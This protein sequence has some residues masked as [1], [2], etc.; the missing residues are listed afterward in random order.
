MIVTD[1]GL[2]NK[3]KCIKP[4]EGALNN[5]VCGGLVVINRYC[6]R[7]EWSHV[8]FSFSLCHCKHFR[9]FLLFTQLESNSELYW[10][11]VGVAVGLRYVEC[12]WFLAFCTSVFFCVLVISDYIT[13]NP[14]V[15]LWTTHLDLWTTFPSTPINSGPCSHESHLFE[16]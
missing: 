10:S 16:L 6:S 5:M 12:L 11:L 13:H 3:W 15:P 4:F 7:K 9:W 1:A 2:K 8:E 14:F